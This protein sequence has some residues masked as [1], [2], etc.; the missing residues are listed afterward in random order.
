[1]WQV[2]RRDNP[3]MTK[4]RFREFY[5]CDFDIAGTYDPLL[6]EAECLKI[7][8]EVLASLALG[9]YTIKLNHRKLLD[10]VF[11]AA[12]VP[13]NLFKTVCSTVDK[14]DKVLFS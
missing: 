11:A 13:P 6:P 3:A 9:A 4:G 5:Q 1:M 2:Y 7:V 10:A 14:L 12:G 8:D